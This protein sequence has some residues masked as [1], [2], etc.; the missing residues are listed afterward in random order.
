MPITAALNMSPTSHYHITDTL[1]MGQGKDRESWVT[2]SSCSDPGLHSPLAL[3]AGHMG[4]QPG[5]RN[6]AVLNPTAG[7]PEK[8]PL[9]PLISTPQAP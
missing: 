1:G 5:K 2:E 4:R 3:T 8:S 7:N 6:S 9:G